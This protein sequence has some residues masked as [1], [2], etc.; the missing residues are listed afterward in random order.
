MSYLKL[1]N[2]RNI[3]FFITLLILTAIGFRLFKDLERYEKTVVTPPSG[4]AVRD[5]YLVFRRWMEQS[6]V[7]LSYG[8]TDDLA[9]GYDDYDVIFLDTRYLSENPEAPILWKSLQSWLSVGGELRIF[10]NDD[11]Q[12]EFPSTTMD[13]LNKYGLKVIN[14]SDDNGIIDGRLIQ[15]GKIQKIVTMN[16]QTVLQFSAPPEILSYIETNDGD[17]YH[18]VSLSIGKG[19]MILTGAP[20]FLENY[21]IGE[22]DNADFAWELV[23]GRSGGKSVLFLLGGET[24]VPF[25]DNPWLPVLVI[26][27][28]ITAA[29][30]IWRLLVRRES[31]SAP[32]PQT[33]SDIKLRLAAEGAFLWRHGCTD[34]YLAVCRIEAMRQLARNGCTEINGS[35]SYEKTA[36]RTGCEVESLKRAFEGKQ[37]DGKKA[38]VRYMQIFRIIKDKV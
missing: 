31:M 34:S 9:E 14:I 4:L 21:F 20:V 5:P 7:K 16:S 18:L 10:L 2:R 23:G 13:V 36:L 26:S 15:S 1:L 33:G 6:G 22:L 24:G 3:L 19:R 28:I 30:L 12:N 35:I 27:W 37:A 11:Y 8:S 17:G 25:H 38:F 29:M 32:L